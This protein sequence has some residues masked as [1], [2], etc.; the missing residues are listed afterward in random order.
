MELAAA[1]Q[2]ARQA[3]RL[4]MDHFG[5]ELQVKYK[6]PGNPVTDLDGMTQ[7]LIADRLHRA[8]PDY[9][10]LGEEDSASSE[11][12]SVR[13]IVDPIDGTINY[14][15]DHPIFVVS[16]ALEKAGEITLGVVYAPY[17]D[18]LYAAEKGKGATLNG[19][20]IHVSQTV[21][22][23]KAVLGSGFPYNVWYD[24]KDNLEQWRRF[25]KVALA[26]RTTG[27]AAY[28]LCYVA[29]GRLDGYWELKLETWDAAA[30]TLIVREAGGMVT[31]VDGQPYHHLNQ[32]L[33][34]SNGVL[35]QE[36]LDILN[37]PKDKD[38]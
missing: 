3:G 20:P 28:D 23:D 31:Q 19:I 32:H 38:R 10:F 1:I 33:L 16:I 25:T 11:G 4:L 35:H 18:E 2:A 6:A 5:K 29:A 15:H 7:R 8:F 12:E 30:A 17:L 13:W 26:T 34:A 36:M 27:S 9:G 22:M 24:D 21:E 37:N 14:F